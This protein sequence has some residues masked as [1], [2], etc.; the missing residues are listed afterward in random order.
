[1]LIS[2]KL[3]ATQVLQQRLNYQIIVPDSPTQAQRLAAS[4]LKKFLKL[5]YSKPIIFNGKNNKLKFFI[6]SDNKKQ[7]QNFKKLPVKPSQFGIL[8]QQNSFL[9]TGYDAPGVKPDKSYRHS[10]GTCTAVY[11]FLTKYLGVNFYFPGDNG[12]AVSKNRPLNF[13]VDS[14]IPQ[15]TFT[16]RGISTGINGYTSVEGIIFFRRLLGNIPFWAKH[17][18]YYLYLY[19]W[20]KRFESS[21]PEYLGL[22]KGKRYSGKYPYCLP[23]FSNPAVI[24]QSAADI[25][26]AIKANPHIRTVRIFADC[27]FQFCQCKKCKSMP[28]RKYI[29]ETKENGEMVYGIIKKIMDEVHKSYPEIQFLTQTK[30]YT[31]SGSYFK[32]PQLI[33]L[34]SQITVH[35]LTRR[36]RLPNID[37]SQEIA[38]TEAW[39]KNGVKI[40]LKSYERYPAAKNYPLIKPHLDQNFFKLF[41]GKVT[42]TFKSEATKKSSYAFS[43]LGQYLQMKMLF[44]IN[45]NLNEATGKFCEFAY[46]GAEQEMIAFYS[47]MESLYSKR[48]QYGTPMLN[49]IY[50]ADKLAKAMRLLEAAAKKV[51]PDSQ[52]F[53]SL[54]KEFK[55]FYQ[56]AVAAQE[57]ATTK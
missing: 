41:A 40:V 17:D 46:P 24:K 10:A 51:K 15:P 11:Y 42:G 32:A 44:N 1:M 43:A 36:N 14:D 6:G 47:E 8:R 2:V 12:Y 22:Y 13:T 50:R 37:Y 54:L 18:L 52:Y 16:V 3:P 19:K 38:L 39:N 4:E 33:K 55:L 28:E 57:K 34:G 5:I 56:Q 30:I 25:N 53:T 31:G 21:H 49:D 7:Y 27:P 48:K 20:K 9:L 35:H 45:I 29:G 26:A 23:C